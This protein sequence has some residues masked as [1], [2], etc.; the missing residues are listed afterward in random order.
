MM[1]FLGILIYHF[2]FCQVSLGMGQPVRVNGI[3]NFDDEIA[4]PF[5]RLKMSGEMCPEHSF[6]EGAD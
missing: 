1:V 2:Y 3:A 4:K 5:S 6:N